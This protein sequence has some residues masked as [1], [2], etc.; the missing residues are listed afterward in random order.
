MGMQWAE[1]SIEIAATPDEVFDA[2]TDYETF[3]GWQSAV[4]ATQVT[5]REAASGLGEVVEYEVDGKIRTIRYT[6]RYHY[7]RPEKI[8]WDFLEGHGINRMDGGYELRDSGG[9]TSATYRVGIDVSGIPGPILKR[10]HKATIKKANQDLKAEAERR[11]GSP[12]SSKA[13][14]EPAPTRTP[15]PEPE[16]TPEAEPAPATGSEPRSE[17]KPEP[18]ANEPKGAAEPA[19]K[20]AAAAQSGN[21]DHPFDMLPG[22]LPELARLPGRIMVKIGRRLGG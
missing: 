20:P 13:E 18:P 12:R 3:P 6:L 2:I 16:P 9:G 10:T 8:S 11:A 21:G 22:P 1:H 7:D 17:P 5:E 15:E 14:A 19:A 4:L